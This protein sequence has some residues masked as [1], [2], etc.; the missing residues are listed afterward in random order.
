MNKQ[1]LPLLVAQFLSAFA[2]NAIIFTVIAM[3]M[4]LKN[5]PAWYIPALQESFLVAFVVLAPWVGGIAD[6]HAKSK[7][8]LVANVIKAL[9]AVLLLLKVE[10][11]LA[12]G[13]VGMGAALYSPAK[14]G[15]LPE[16]TSHEKLVKANSWIEG[17]TIFAILLG[18]VVG[19]KLADYSIILALWSTLGLYATSALITLALPVYIAKTEQPTSQIIEFGNQIKLFFIS[20]RARFAI[21]G[22][23][24]FWATAAA[25]RVMLV[26]WAPLV[27]LTKNVSDI[28]ELTLYLALGIIAGAAL[29]PRLIPLEHL[30]RI[31]LPGYLMALLIGVLSFMQNLLPAQIVLFVIGIMGGMFI[32]PVNAAL[33]EL[34]K[35]SIGSGSAV[36]MQNFFQNLAMVAS[37]GLY[38]LASSRGVDPALAMRNLGGLLLVTTF[39]IA[40]RLPK[41]KLEKPN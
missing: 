28:A 25:L 3:V 21:L 4:Q 34:G 29:V 22:A 2:D 24:I 19:A 35:D 31:R 13:I 16:L 38:T 36:A 1:I 32:V 10:P 6:S 33:Q 26:A 40:I 12:Y 23:A 11:L 27:L 5:A 41:P 39:L 15:I 9:G 37:V 8:L 30:R 18:T 14:Y 20:P 17:S 7:V